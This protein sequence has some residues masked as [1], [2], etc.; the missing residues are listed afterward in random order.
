MSFRKIS[1]EIYLENK[2]TSDFIECIGNRVISLD[3]ISYLFNDQPRATFY[4]EVDSIDLSQFGSS[5]YYI[6]VYDTKYST[7][8][9]FFQ[10]N[11]THNGSEGFIV[12]YGNV[13]S[14]GSLGEFSYQVSDTKVNSGNL[15]FSPTKYLYNSY[16]IR[17][18]KMPI[19]N[20]TGIG[21]SSSNYGNGFAVNSLWTGIT[22]SLTPTAVG[23]SSFLATTYST[24]KFSIQ[25][26]NDNN[27][28][29]KQF[30]EFILINSGS[31]TYLY[32]LDYGSINTDNFDVTSSSGLGTFGST[33]SSGSVYLN[34]TPNAGLN[35][36]VRLH[37]TSIH[38]SNTGVGSTSIGTSQIL[39]SYTSIGSSTSPVAT[40]ISGF[41][42]SLYN[43]SDYLIEIKDTTNTQFEVS[44][45][46]LIH[47]GSEIYYSQFGGASSNSGIGTFDARF[48]GSEV[49]LMFTPPVNVNTTAKVFQINISKDSSSVGVV[50]FSTSKYEFI[51]ATYLAA[52]DDSS[53]TFNLSH[54]GDSLFYKEFVGSSST[55]VELDTNTFKIK[56][57]FF[58]TGEQITYTPPTLDTRIGIATTSV[59]GIGVT[60]KLPTTLFAVKTAEDRF[61]VADTASNALT[62]PPVILDLSSLAAASQVLHTF[63]SSV[64]PT[65]KTVITLDNA[66]Q[67]PMV[68][69][70]LAMPL[71]ENITDIQPTFNVVG[72]VSFFA[73][74]ILRIDDEYF[75]I[76]SVI[77]NHFTVDR[78]WLNSQ[79]ASHS[80]GSTVTKYVGDYKIDKN[81]ISFIEAPKGL[82]GYSGLQTSSTF[83]GRVFLK[84][85]QSDTSS[86]TYSSNYLFDDIANQFNGSTKSFD[87]KNNGS[88]VTGVS[89]NNSLILIN[90]VVQHP[91]VNYNISEQSGITSIAFIGS[92]SSITYDVNT[93][94]IPKGGIIVSVATSS[95][96]G[97]Q[98]LVSAGGTAII[99]GL[100]TIS[101]IAIGNSGS[102]YRSGIQTN[103]SV[104]A[105][106]SVGIVTIGTANVSS[107]IITSVTITNPGSGY[108]SSNPPKIGFDPP[109]PYENLP[110]SGSSTGI[111]A[112][113]TISVGYGLSV[114]NYQITNY[115]SNYKSGDVLTILSGGTV[116]VPTNS[117][118]GAAFTSFRLSITEVYNDIFSG[119]TFGQLLKLDSIDNQFNG[120]E[121]VFKLKYTEN[122][123]Q[124]LFTYRPQKGSQIDLDQNFLIFINDVLQLPKESYTIVGG[125]LRFTEPPELGD[126]CFIYFFKGSDSSVKNTAV[127]NSI[128]IGDNVQILSYPEIRNAEDSEIERTVVGIETNTTNILN[129]N[130]YQNNGINDEKDYLR[131]LSYVKQTSDLIIDGIEHPKDRKTLESRIKPFSYLI[132][133]VSS[134][135]TEIFVDY[136]VPLFNEYDDYPEIL[137]SIKIMEQVEKTSGI[138]TAIVSGIGSISSIVISDGG[139]GFTTNPIVSIAST[140]GV[141]TAGFIVQTSNATAISSISGVGTVSLISVVNGGLGYTS[142]NPPQVLIPQEKQISELILDVKYDGDF[143]I[144]TGIGSTSVGIASTGLIF[145]LYIPLESPLRDSTLM[146]TPITNSGIKT[147]YY[148]IVQDSNVGSSITSYSDSS[149]TS[150]VGVGTTFI[151]NVYKVVGVTTVIGDAVGV[152]QT[153][154]TRVTVSV[155]NNSI[156]SGSSDFYGNYSWGRI[157]D[158][159]RPDSKSF[160]SFTQNGVSGIQTSPIIV[161]TIELSDSYELY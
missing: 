123:I 28:N 142:T 49:E 33:L 161:R 73:N 38:S 65:T 54:K 153:T 64:E 106:T 27:T 53:K 110:L 157:Y 80:I 96:Y 88:N 24:S 121:K 131:P 104:K 92:A 47:D 94:S 7:E 46:S 11:F 58:N 69:T 101:S 122:A 76:R 26:V 90:Q 158:I 45:I 50:S 117:S 55:V 87:L 147:G 125:L 130:T 141:G 82:M 10:L 41:S 44:Q 137:R 89:T 134:A 63:E 79:F 100:G 67:S 68:R 97:Y 160:T 139:S 84:T 132:S 85:S 8:S 9:E 72:I 70:N 91:G 35:A 18:V 108:T 135:S 112:S 32:D 21:T 143:G 13:D 144:V 103:I 59:S 111:G 14:L 83:S 75:R 155:S 113:V 29:I 37:Q 31:G 133:N 159:K 48:S 57:H 114:V 93:A 30:N 61:K 15:I 146:T 56:N 2:I 148:F 152:G 119:W 74:D 22:S 126:K 17:I 5:K 138:A 36:T 12:P 107:G 43:A 34:F 120:I 60:N 81:K 150:I 156:S 77:G 51:N 154:L 95:N 66:V 136:A 127:L 71:A 151:D 6:Y 86:E 118:V 129:T 3:D 140:I 149:R 109:L 99:S 62:I 115:G 39:T 4:S 78:G 102:G 98:P 1:N 128:K 25:V 124:K 19:F 20:S 40:R 52:S 16:G 23:I 42:S 105:L 116:G 145:D